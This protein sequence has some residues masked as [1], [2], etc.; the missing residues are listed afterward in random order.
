M[1]DGADQ[2]RWRESGGRARWGV[3]KEKLPHMVHGVNQGERE[4]GE[5][6]LGLAREHRPE[7]RGGRYRI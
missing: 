6:E 2:R 4:R 7:K 3:E 5:R 1:A